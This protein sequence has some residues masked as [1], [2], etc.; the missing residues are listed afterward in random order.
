MHSEST[1]KAAE[2][3]GRFGIYALLLVGVGLAAGIFPTATPLAVDL[4]LAAGS[5]TAI[6]AAA[7]VGGARGA[8]H[9]LPLQIAPRASR[10][11]SRGQPV[12][13]FRAR[14]GRGRTLTE[15]V[16]TVSWQGPDGDEVPLDPWV[17]ADTLCGPFTFLA[18]DPAGRVDGQGQFVV[19]LQVQSAGRAWSAERRIAVEDV[20][21]G[22]FEGVEM[23][24]RGLRFTD[25]W[26]QVASPLESSDAE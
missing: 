25:A 22:P 9:G 3:F 7:F 21:E 16:A 23:H 8:V 15:P 26:Q 10:G 13:R 4:M 19:R 11:V 12:F 1:L 17:P 18:H 2:R 20:V 5:A 24:R 6:G 14:L